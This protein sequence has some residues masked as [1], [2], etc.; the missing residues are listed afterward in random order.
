MMCDEARAS[1][2]RRATS[3]P[4][5][6]GICTSRN[7]TSGCRRSIVVSASMPLP[8]W[9]STSTPPIW[10]SRYPSSSRASCSSSTSTARKSILRRYPLGQPEFRNLDARAGALPG[11]AGELQVVVR[12]V[13]RAQALVD[14]AETDAAAHGLLQTLLGHPEPVVVDRDH[15][16]S[17]GDARADGDAPSTHLTREAVLDRIL[18]ER[19]QQHAGH[20]D[21]ECFGADVLDHF[22]LRPE[23]HDLDVEVFVNR[24]ELFA[25]RHEMVSA[26]HETAKQTGKL[27]DEHAGRFRL[28][29]DQRRYRRQGVEEKV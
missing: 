15:R 27:G 3:N 20:D 17:F 19:L 24:L 2:I 21:V 23:P 12:P 10:P 4:V 14:V 29:A 22:Q 7:T 8:A 25:Q 11:H 18:D 5:S 26:A 16:V 6:P 28:R 13:D 1:S 9:P